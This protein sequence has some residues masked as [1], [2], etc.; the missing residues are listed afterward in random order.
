MVGMDAVNSELTPPAIH[1][2]K[3]EAIVVTEEDRSGSTNS[4]IV[5]IAAFSDDTPLS[6]FSWIPSTITITLSIR[7][8]S[9]KT[10]A[11]IAICCSTPPIPLNIE[12]EIKV[13]TGNINETNNPIRN[14]IKRTKK[15]PKRSI[16]WRRE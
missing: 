8:P 3:N 13:I 2:G 14:P 15:P 1:I 4:E 5:S 10:N 16:D 11:A 7:I 12:K 6:I 9:D